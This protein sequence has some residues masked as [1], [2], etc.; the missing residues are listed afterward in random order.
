MI[1]PLAL[2]PMLISAAREVIR[3]EWLGAV[4]H[5]TDGP[6]QHPS[7]QKVRTLEIHLDLPKGVIGRQKLSFANCLNFAFKWANS[8]AWFA[9]KKS[10]W[11]R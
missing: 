1:L 9:K 11:H 2:L 6:A 3:L 4:R 8:D 5:S 7:R 10:Y